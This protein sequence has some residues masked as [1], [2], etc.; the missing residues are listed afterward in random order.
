MPQPYAGYAIDSVASLKYLTLVERYPGY[1]VGYSRLVLEKNSWY[2]F[3]Y[4]ATDTADD[5][6]VVTPLDGVG[7]WLKHLRLVSHTHA[8]YLTLGAADTR[9][10]LI[11]HDHYGVYSPVDHLHT[12]VYSPVSH[13]HDGTYAPIVHTHPYLD[14][15]TA[16]GRYLLATSY[17]SHS[18][19]A[20]LNKLSEGGGKLLYDGNPLGLSRATANL[21]VTSLASG[22]YS[23]HSV[24]MGKSAVL[25]KVTSDYPARI[26][27]YHSD[28]ARVADVARSTATALVTNGYNDHGCLL[29]VSVKVS[30]NPSYL[31]L[32]PAATLYNKQETGDNSQI[33]LTVNNLDTVT[34]TIAL[35]FTYIPLEI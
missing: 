15:A 7:R 6:L 16:D 14:Q 21:T 22:A 35:S 30:S 8:E 28:A 12:G 13:N 26:R 29:D 27:V 17:Q 2:T 5:D 34:R 1:D 25:L 32:A 20:T 11:G 33:Y 31:W 9:Y 3:K 4:A 10:S 18:N 23:Y 24:N 19:Y